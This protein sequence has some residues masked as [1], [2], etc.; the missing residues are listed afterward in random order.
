ML[1]RDKNYATYKLFP[2]ARSSAS[3]NEIQEAQLLQ[4]DR[5]TLYVIEYFAKSFKINQGQ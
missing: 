5:E 1:M 4:R 2:L 3:N